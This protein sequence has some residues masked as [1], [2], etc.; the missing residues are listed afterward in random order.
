MSHI[1]IRISPD[2]AQTIELDSDVKRTSPFLQ[3]QERV[4]GKISDTLARGS[5]DESESLLL[6]NVIDVNAASRRIK[7]A[8][9]GTEL[10]L[11]Y[12]GTDHVA[13]L[14][15]DYRL[16]IGVE[17]ISAP[18]KPDEGLPHEK[19]MQACKQ[20]SI[21]GYTDWQSGSVKEAQ[22]MIDYTGREP[23]LDT[24]YFPRIRPKL[25]WTRTDVVGYPSC[26]WG[27]NLDLGDVYGYGRNNQGF[28]LA[29]R[30]V[31]Q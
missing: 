24:N 1:T 26:A 14:F 4:L 12:A 30:R 7:I 15:P 19:C 8:A 3:F 27:V 10:P 11:E 29:V 22:L 16:M 6:S 20:Q 31:G 13:V 28:G 9:D 21:A 23:A 5:A 17:S 25:H 18:K 2:G